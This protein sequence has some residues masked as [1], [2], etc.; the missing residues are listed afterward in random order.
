MRIGFALLYAE[1]FFRCLRLWKRRS[2]ATDDPRI[3]LTILTALGYIAFHTLLWETES[4]YGQVMIPLLGILCA[5]P[6][7]ALE[8]ERRVRQRTKAAG[9]LTLGVLLV[10][11]VAF[12]V[13]PPLYAPKGHDVA[14]QQSQLSLQFDAKKTHIRPYDTLSQ[15][16]KL[17]HQARHFSV[18]LA[19]AAEFSG[20]LINEQTH[21]HY[22]LKRTF[23]ALT[24]KRTLPEGM[25]RI[26]LRNDLQRSQSVLITKT[27]SYRLAPYPLEIDQHKYPY[28][29]FVYIFS[30]AK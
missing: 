24:L 25:Y 20:T 3:M 11:L 30:R 22:E 5:V 23:D 14:Q 16:V 21:Q 9:R 15:R 10:A 19:P 12:M 13:T 8:S 27:I 17:N 7:L 26:Q 4:R 6:S 2:R 1:T 18:S 29:S 28:W